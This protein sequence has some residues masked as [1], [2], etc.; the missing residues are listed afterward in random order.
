MSEVDIQ[1]GRRKL[2]WARAHMPIHA[3]LRERFRQDPPLQGLTVAVCSH[4]EAK[5]GVFIETLAAG[6]AQVVFTGSE[7]Q[8]TQDDVVAALNEQAGLTGYA[9]HGADEEAFQ[10]S[11]MAVVDHRPQ[12]ILDDAAEL[13]SRLA[14]HRPELLA[15]LIGTC[16]QTTTGVRRLEA[17]HADGVMAFPSYAVNDSP[18]KHYF[19][20]VHG[21]GES[22]LSNIAQCTNLLFAGKEVVVAGYGYC[23]R[24][25]AEKA[26]GWQAQV[27]VTE[28]EPR[29]AL[30]AHMNGFRVASMAEAAT[31]GDIF[32]TATGNPEVL[33]A[34][35]FERMKDGAVL[36]N[37]GHFNIEIDT[38]ALGGLAETITEVRPGIDEYRLRDGRCINVIADGRLAN[39]A[40]PGAMGHPA[41]VMDQT[42]ATQIMA[43]V[44]LVARRGELGAGVHP[45][46]DGVDRSVAMLKLESLGIEL[47]RL[48]DRQARFDSAWRID[49]IRSQA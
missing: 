14:H 45:V 21:T 24:G 5:T 47:D 32:I 48:T 18:M 17:M 20:N 22:T 8:S 15:D 7:P 37:A 3:I 40:A 34:A 33:R 29:R 2:A 41:E 11:H 31:Y 26:R 30:E 35:H 16:E 49:D 23:G 27:T 39:L 38:A 36:A 19:D 1:L 13:T 28:V 6:G 44:D 42:F 12:F 10:A 25:L 9:R 4:L 46:P 43:A